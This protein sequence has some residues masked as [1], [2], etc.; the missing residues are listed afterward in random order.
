MVT[1]KGENLLIHLSCIMV[2]WIYLAFELLIE[3]DKIFE[4]IALDSS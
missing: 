1:L 3:Q 4:D 2:N